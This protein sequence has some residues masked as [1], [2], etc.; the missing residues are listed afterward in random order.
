L[1]N[2]GDNPGMPPDKNHGRNPEHNPGHNPGG[3]PE[4]SD[5]KFPPE[6]WALVALNFPYSA[7]LHTGYLVL[8]VLRFNDG[9]KG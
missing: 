2:P 7:A 8:N 1:R 9:V 6:N 4:Y 3:K 5:A